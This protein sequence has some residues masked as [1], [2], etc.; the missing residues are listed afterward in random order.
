LGININLK[1]NPLLQPPF[2]PAEKNTC[3][4]HSLFL[5]SYWLLRLFLFFPGTGKTLAKAQ[6]DKSEY[7]QDMAPEQN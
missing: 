6:V 1:K 3:S 5:I 2:I 4:C 7:L